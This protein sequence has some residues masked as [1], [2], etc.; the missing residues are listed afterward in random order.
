[1][2]HSAFMACRGLFFAASIEDLKV[3]RRQTGCFKQAVDLD[4]PLEAGAAS[5]SQ[6][7]GRE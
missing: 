7:I 6:G 5:T 4:I 3:P 1:M 2:H